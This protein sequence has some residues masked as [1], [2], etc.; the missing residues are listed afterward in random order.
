MKLSRL[1]GALLVAVAMLLLSFAGDSR[2]AEQRDPSFRLLSRY[3]PME[4][5]EA[6]TQTFAIAED[7][8]G[9][10]YFGNIGGVVEFDGVWWR[11][12][13]L[14]GDSPA[15]VLASLPDGRIAVAGMDELGYLETN[16]TGATVY[17]SL[18]DKLP[19]DQRDSGEFLSVHSTRDGVVFVSTKL[20]AVWRDDE[21]RVI[22]KLEAGPLP[23]RSFMV[24]G[25][26]WLAFP[27]GL[28][29]I[30]GDT[31]ER[32][33]GGELFK[34]RRVRMILPWSEGRQL[35]AVQ[36]EGLRLFDGRTEAPF[37]PAVSDLANRFRVMKGVRLA[38]GRYAIATLQ[39]GV[40]V[41]TPEGEIDELID[42]STGL[43]DEDIAD[44]VV[45]SD[46]SLWLAMDSS[47]ARVEASSAL[48]VV[49]ARGGL[50]G[51][52]VAIVRHQGTIYAGTTSGLY[53]LV[54]PSDWLRGD[55]APR[56]IAHPVGENVRSAW[57]FV[58]A[59]A[60][61]LVGTGAG[62][63]VV[64][65][66]GKSRVLEGTADLL[67]YCL[68]QSTV[69]PELIWAGM[70]EGLGVVRRTGSVWTW[71]GLVD[72]GPENIRTIVEESA[73]K[74]W[75]GTGFDGVARVELT[76]DAGRLPIAR[77]K[78]FGA[79][80]ASVFRLA[81][82]IVF[83]TDDKRILQLDET[84]GKFSPDA[85]LGE[86]GNESI[87]Y[88]LADDLEGNI[89]MNTQPV[90][91]GRRQARGAYEFDDRILMNMP[92][93]DIQAIY[94][95]YDGSVW[96]G[97]EAGL[98]RNDSRL[99]RRPDAPR[100]PLVRRVTVNGEPIQGA[101]GVV[102]IPAGARRVRFET[103]SVSYERGVQYQYRLEPIESAWTPWTNEPVT[104]FTNL[105]EGD[106]TLQVRSR[107]PRGDV[108]REQSWSFRVLPPW[109][110]TTWAW[111]CWIAMGLLILVALPVARNRALR[112]RATLLEQQV[113]EKT[114]A[115]THLVEQLRIANEKLEELSFD[116]PLTGIPNRRRFDQ[117]LDAEWKRAR[118]AGKPVAFVLIDLDHFKSLNDT[119][120]HQVGDEALKR[121]AVYLERSLRRTGDL[122]A[123]Y[124]G[125]E[126]TVILPN[127][128][129][130][131]AMHFAEQLRDGIEKLAIQ[132][133]GSPFRYVT[134]SFGVASILPVESVEPDVMIAAADRAL[135]RAKDAGRN[136]VRAAE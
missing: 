133:D 29:R 52:P 5:K 135:Y 68:V 118:R 71:E 21:I 63:L 20:I 95:E 113:T 54:R 64:E 14:R 17:V 129:L 126:F 104:E 83:T 61:L 49:D 55:L 22:R 76:G 77:V 9:V 36:D 131:G 85:L 109:Y 123:R 96:F 74:L 120:G 86:L 3:S 30:V 114:G 45:T 99:P 89:W 101:A 57:A 62:V 132:N 6:G 80:E 91:V 116:D 13:G 121:I 66:D 58:S 24:D 18:V 70:R 75:A 119:K 51:T 40:I 46:G 103:A 19:E 47:I 105:W 111:L 79:S 23:P 97:T 53:K 42:S 26:V 124:G 67:S 12:I 50:R 69:D 125:E 130:P 65:S 31:L 15:F 115:L 44:A 39:G 136:C 8:R 7:G 35:V 122:V 98:V 72:G 84:T 107:S 87:P 59:G 60:D 32:V 100:A 4:A 38:D 108:S 102:E 110:R 112:A 11:L 41:M 81:G 82:R 73:G 48:T 16:A 33:P 78:T 56:R 94:V 2:A 88:A 37:A 25:R 106:Y 28:W 1:G 127:T 90:G 134:A 34:D 43:P 92:G 117:A 93:N 10:L 128:E 27:D